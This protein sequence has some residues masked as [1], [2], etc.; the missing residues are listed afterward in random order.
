MKFLGEEGSLEM[1][2][3]KDSRVEAS[4]ITPSDQFREILGNDKSPSV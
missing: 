4:S 2:V 1:I 3:V